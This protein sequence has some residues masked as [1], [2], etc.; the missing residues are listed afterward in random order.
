MTTSVE[1]RDNN[2]FSDDGVFPPGQ[3]TRSSVGMAN[4]RQHQRVHSIGTTGDLMS[5]ANSL[6]NEYGAINLESD[7]LTFS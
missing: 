5:G 7:A 6:R 1:T 3:G 4:N 2:L